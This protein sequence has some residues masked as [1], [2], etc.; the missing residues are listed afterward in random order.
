[1][2]RLALAFHLA[3][4]ARLVLSQQSVLA[5]AND[6]LKRWL[7]VHA[8]GSDPAQSL[9]EWQELID[10]CNTDELIRIMTEDS[11]EGQRLRQSSPFAGILSD[12][13]REELIAPCG[14][15]TVA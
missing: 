15:R 7:E 4:A 2:N 5:Q 11:D 6:N 10:R 13:E 14:Q 3:V 8:L 12:Q 9:K 1:M